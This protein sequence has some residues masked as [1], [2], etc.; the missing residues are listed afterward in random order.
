MPPQSLASDI[1]QTSM[2]LLDEMGARV[3]GNIHD[4]L[5]I[6][7]PAERAVEQARVVERVMTVDALTRLAELGLRLPPGL[8]EVE[9][10]VGPWGLGKVLDL[11][12]VVKASEPQ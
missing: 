7:A 5:L 11:S 3:V 6:E 8:I 1:T 12:P 2:I 4:A 9:I 10:A